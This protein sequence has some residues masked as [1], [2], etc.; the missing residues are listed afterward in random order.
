M[1]LEQPVAPAPAQRDYPNLAL[2]LLGL[3]G[4]E[5]SR[6]WTR[7]QIWR[8]TIERDRSLR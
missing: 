3:A 4:L 6:D 8:D 2:G 1:R 5:I 7:R